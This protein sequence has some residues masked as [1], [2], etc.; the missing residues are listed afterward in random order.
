VNERKVYRRDDVFGIT[1]ELPLN[2]VVRRS[3]DE[4]LVENLTR[5]KHLVIYGSSKQGKTSLRK[6]CLK[7]EDYIVVQCSNTWK[8]EDVNAN[9]LKRAGFELSLSSTTTTSGK[10]KIS[11]TLGSSLAAGFSAI[12]KSSLKTEVKGEHEAENEVEEE[13]KPLD[14][15]AC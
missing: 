15:G 8:V 1:R 11:A 7:D 2:Y 9:I 10:N 5:D 6:H 13:F 4:R 12:F 14:L 3:A